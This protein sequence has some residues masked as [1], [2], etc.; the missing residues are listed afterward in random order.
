M[1]NLDL[2]VLKLN[3]NWSPVST[4]PVSK[5]FSDAFAGAVTF[6]KFQEGYPSIFRIEDWLL[7][8]VEDG[9]DY[10]TTSKMHGLR[11]IAC[12]RVCI[13]T[14][15]DKLLA[16]E[17]PCTPDNLLKRYGHKD[18]VTG[19][20]LKRENFSREH[21]VP[22]SRGGGGGWE[23]LVPM[24]R[25]LNSQRGNKPY[26]TIGHRRPRVLE[27]PRPILPI[28]SIVNVHGWPEWDFCHIPRQ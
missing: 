17:Q 13:C 1:S 28:N 27:P 3:K 16:K 4:I 7:M 14:S 12:P 8:E 20:R 25:K 19:K 11:R 23:N 15:Y 10:I 22:R 26:D 21:V 9:Q 2:P 24:D 5:A 6:L 18:A